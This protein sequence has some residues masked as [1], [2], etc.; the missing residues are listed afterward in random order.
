MANNENT[1][2]ILERIETLIRESRPVPHHEV[3]QLL[4]KADKNPGIDI[5]KELEIIR[6]KYNKDTL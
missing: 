1:L 6:K 4:M 5:K 3:L 2:P